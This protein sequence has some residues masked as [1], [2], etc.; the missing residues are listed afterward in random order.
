MKPKQF[1]ILPIFRTWFQQNWFQ[2]QN[3]PQRWFDYFLLAKPESIW[4]PTWVS[5]LVFVRILQTIVI[6]VWHLSNIWGCQII[7][8]AVFVYIVKKKQMH[9]HAQSDVWCWDSTNSVLSITLVTSNSKSFPIL[10]PTVPSKLIRNWFWFRTA[11]KCALRLNSFILCINVKN[12]SI[13]LTVRATVIVLKLQI[14][15]CQDSR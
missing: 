13:K 10:H 11:I 1:W 15:F 3:H 7:T 8:I 14:S 2:I 9:I 6:I 4:H 5:W 12:L